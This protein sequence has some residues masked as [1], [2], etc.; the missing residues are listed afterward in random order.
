[1]TIVDPGPQVV[2]AGAE[3]YLMLDTL[4]G[5]E[6]PT[7]SMAPAHVGSL[8]VDKSG[9]LRGSAPSA[10]GSYSITVTASVGGV[11]TARTTFS[12]VVLPRLKVTHPGSGEVRLNGANHCL[13]DA[14]DSAKAGTAVRIGRCSDQADQRWEFA[15][16]GDFAAKGLMKIHGKCLAI[17]RGT[18]NGARATIRACTASSDEQWTYQGSGHFKNA[19]AGRCLAIHGSL[20]AGKQ[21]VVWSCAGGADA[22]WVLPGAPVLSAVPGL[23]L[24]DPGA[25]RAAGTPIA[26]ASCSGSSGQRWTA[27]RNGTLETAG[28]CLAVRAGSM[29][30]GAAVELDK[31]TGRTAQQWQRGPGGQLINAKSGRCLADPGNSRVSGTK[32]TQSDCYEMPGEIWVIS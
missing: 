18:R 8:I 11:G 12:I 23:C 16:T 9:I 2:G 10:P 28:K 25:A 24:A 7:Y 32:L 30:T 26:V 13:T 5:T 14:G 4:P 6:T 27:N 17:S 3:I 15:P 22:S 1:M 29:L 31:C 19:A 20:T 21:A